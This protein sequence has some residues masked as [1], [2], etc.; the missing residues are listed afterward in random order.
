MKYN[1]KSNLVVLALSFLTASAFACGGCKEHNS[2]GGQN[3]G[4]TVSMD[5]SASKRYVA[6]PSQPAS[7]GR[8]LFR[9]DKK[10]NVQV[11][12]APDSNKATRPA[13]EAYSIAN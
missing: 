5:D 10:G 4:S 3:T 6:A 8:Q 9:M 7:A 2:G 12:S 13:T 11:T 1:S